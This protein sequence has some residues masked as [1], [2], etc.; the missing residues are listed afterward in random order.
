MID[1]RQI[2]ACPTAVPLWILLSRVEEKAGQLIKAR[3]ILEKAR[4]KNPKSPELWLEAVRVENRAGLKNIGQSLMAKGK[5]I[6]PSFMAKCQHQP[7]P[8][9]YKDTG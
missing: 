2:K 9:G 6:C 5:T 8:Y 1:D 4:L 7:E 3:S